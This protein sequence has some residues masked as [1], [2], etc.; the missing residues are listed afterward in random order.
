MGESATA[1]PAQHTRRK[2]SRER[3]ACSQQPRTPPRSV[4]VDL[5]PPLRTKNGA[6]RDDAKSGR[7][8]GAR[9]EAGCGSR[10]R[11]R[12]RVWR[13]E[14][15]LSMNTHTVFSRLTTNEMIANCRTRD[16]S[17]SI[18]EFILIAYSE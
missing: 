14:A 8:G 1:E 17:S 9:R 7:H 13:N 6:E 10:R 4:L 11:L 5:V 18:K 3:R 2:G 15:H 16:S 12:V